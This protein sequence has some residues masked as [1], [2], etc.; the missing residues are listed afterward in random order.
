VCVC[1]FSAKQT[2]VPVTIEVL[3]PVYARRVQ[4]PIYAV[5]VRLGVIRMIF[6]VTTVWMTRHAQ[7]Y[8]WRERV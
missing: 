4:R 2:R 6:E 8:I 3:V 5:T 7:A 1:V